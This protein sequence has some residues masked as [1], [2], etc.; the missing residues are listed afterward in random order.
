MLNLV[1]NFDKYFIIATLTTTVN[2]WFS[3]ASTLDL[4]VL[5]T[6]ESQITS[7]IHEGKQYIIV[8][9]HKRLKID[10][11]TRVLKMFIKIEF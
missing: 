3:K 1:L 6:L 9:F 5:A 4:K 8:D 7:E 10:F 2:K 11:V